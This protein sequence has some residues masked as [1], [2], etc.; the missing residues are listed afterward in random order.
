[1]KRTWTL[2][3]YA[4]EI[5]TLISPTFSLDSISLCYRAWRLRFLE[6][7]NKRSRSRFREVPSL[8]R[9]YLCT[10]SIINKYLMLFPFQINMLSVLNIC[11]CLHDDAYQI[12]V[13]CFIEYNL[14]SCSQIGLRKVEDCFAG[15]LD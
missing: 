13:S 7:R 8:K 1:M 11:L 6:K 10:S 12:R 9:R 14:L 3:C 4:R 15:L 2:R 5:G